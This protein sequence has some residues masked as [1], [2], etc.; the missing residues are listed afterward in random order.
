MPVKKLKE[1][2]DKNNIR[3]VTIRH[4]QAYNAQRVAASAHIPGDELAK[5][6]MVKI[7][8][9]MAMAVLPA[10]FRVNFDTLKLLTGA[11]T[12]ELANEM[13]FKYMFPDCEV[14]AMPPFGNLYDMEVYVA[15]K[16]RE[17]EEIS[18]CAGTHFELIKMA[19][20][21][22]ERLVKPRILR[23]STAHSMN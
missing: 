11:T 16:L 9:K 19:Y 5:T 8:G 22:F 3:Y 21:D 10:S 18:F 7:D 20:D 23:F 15:E 13:E 12:I 4:S 14:G 6:V 1:F 2:L 17:D